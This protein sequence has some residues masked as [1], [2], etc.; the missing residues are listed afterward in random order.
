MLGVVLAL[1]FALFYNTVYGPYRQQTLMTYVLGEA[2]VTERSESYSELFSITPYG[3]ISTMIYM[4]NKMVIAVPNAL[5][6]LTPEQQDIVLRDV[7]SLRSEVERYIG[8]KPTHYR[9]VLS[10]VRL[11][12]LEYLI[13]IDDEEKAR[14]LTTS[15]KYIEHLYGLSPSNPRSSWEEESLNSLK[16]LN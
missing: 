4:M 3:R 10:F 11:L 2:T 13:Q 1:S 12:R 5:G 14:I 16:A 9:F 7:H 15:E 6:D 8:D